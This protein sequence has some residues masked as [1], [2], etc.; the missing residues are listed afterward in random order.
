MIDVGC[1]GLKAGV[2]VDIIPVIG[3]SYTLHDPC[4][5]SFQ[6]D[7]GML[8]LLPPKPFN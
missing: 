7:N 4:V 5:G 3:H 6:I 1:R 8:E 2:I